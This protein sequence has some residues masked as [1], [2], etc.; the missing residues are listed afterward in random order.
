MSC[1]SRCGHGR[2]ASL[3]W[4][5]A[6]LWACHSKRFVLRTMR[7][8]LGYPPPPTRTCLTHTH[9]THTLSLTTEQHSRVVCAV[10]CVRSLRTPASP[11]SCCCYG[12]CSSAVITGNGLHALPLPPP[13]LLYSHRCPRT[14][15]SACNRAPWPAERQRRAAAQDNCW[16]TSTATLAAAMLLAIATSERQSHTERYLVSLSYVVRP[17]LCCG[18]VSSNQLFSHPRSS[19][20]SPAFKSS[21]ALP[22]TLCLLHSRRAASLCAKQMQMQIDTRPTRACRTHACSSRARAGW[23]TRTPLGG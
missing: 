2:E 11:T 19:F 8:I 7:P 16:K 5:R 4:H 13:P 22:A 3:S 1:C 20:P 21:C 9:Y 14:L 15:R 10:R 12:R 17:S 23:Q 18:W 6:K